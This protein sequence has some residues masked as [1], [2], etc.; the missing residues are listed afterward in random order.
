MAE[1]R[2]D[3]REG[4]G[5]G[6]EY[7][8][9]ASQYFSRRGGKFVYLNINGHANMCASY[10]TVSGYATC[11]TTNAIFGWLNTPKDADGYNAWKSSSTAGADKGFVIY[12]LDGVF[13]MPY[14]TTSASITATQVGLGA[15]IVIGGSTYT[16]VQYACY[17]ATA[18]SCC[19]QI[20][21]FDKDNQTAFV[22]VKPEV[23]QTGM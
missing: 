23:K 9:A 3:Q 18:A 12:D 15:G 2:Y 13:E 21:D 19:L 1:I 7:P 14:Y 6:R 5:K 22:K 20:V 4:T 17:K 11:A 10:S 8:I 16:T